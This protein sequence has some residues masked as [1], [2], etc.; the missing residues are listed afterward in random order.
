M[1]DKYSCVGN[2]QPTKTR[3]LFT[4]F[5]CVTLHEMA[6]ASQDESEATFKFIEEVHNCPAVWDVSSVAYKDTKTNK[7]NG[8][9]SGQTGFRLN[10]S[11]FSFLFLLFSSSVSLFDVN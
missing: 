11:T 2:C 3:A 9:A 4:P 6:H 5:I 10:L 1:N 7:K 8:G